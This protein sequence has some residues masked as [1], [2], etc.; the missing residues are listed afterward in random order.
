MTTEDTR[1]EDT[2]AADTRKVAELLKDERIAVFTT[3]TPDGTLMSRPM[4]M[5]QV[6]FD[7]DL[8]FFASRSSRKVAQVTANPQVNVATSGSDSW[9]SLT[10]HAVVFDDLA[11]KQ[12]LWNPVVEA[13]FPNG[14]EDPDVVLL[15][16]DAA[17]AEYWDSP[18]GRLASVFSFAKAKVT[19]QPYSGGENETVTL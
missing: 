15:R 18:G 10:G 7:G 16:V 1:A 9:V 6:E 13:W 11:K 12:Q 14:P 5:Q 4:S 8:W 3:I 17:S 19:G 2:R